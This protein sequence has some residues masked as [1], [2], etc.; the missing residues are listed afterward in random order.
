MSE[1]PCHLTIGCL[2]D[3]EALGPHVSGDQCKGAGFIIGNEDNGF[4][5]LRHKNQHAPLVRHLFE[6]TSGRWSSQKP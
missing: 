1:L 4:F 2:D 6:S 3:F 5:I